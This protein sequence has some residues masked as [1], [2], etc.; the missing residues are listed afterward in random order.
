MDKSFVTAMYQ[1]KKAN[2]KDNLQYILPQYDS[3]C[4]KYYDLKDI[5]KD[6]TLVIL[7][8][9]ILTGLTMIQ[10][11]FNYTKNARKLKDMS[12][13]FASVV[14]TN[15]G[16][17]NIKNLIKAHGR[18]KKDTVITGSIIPEWESRSPIL[19]MKYLDI[20]TSKPYITAVT[21][22][23]IGPDTNCELLHPLLKKFLFSPEA[24]KFCSKNLDFEMN[25]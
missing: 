16:I 9:C 8:D 13:I 20:L 23:Y 6:S 11:A 18:D 19:D 25:L 21:L 15:K 3:W 24:Q 1:Y 22:P 12:L 14:G 4:E 5:P 10:D 2:K 17:E 7:D